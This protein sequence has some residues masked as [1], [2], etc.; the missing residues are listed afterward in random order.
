[1]EKQTLKIVIPMAGLGTRLRPLTYSKP[2]QLVTLAGKA[3]LDHVLDTLSGIP[4]CYE[5]ELINIVGYLGE[6]IEAHITRHYPHLRSHYVVQDDPRGQSHAIYLARH[7]LEGPMLVIFADTLIQTDLSC[8]LDNH[9][10][11]IA[12][13]KPVP[14]PRRFGVAELGEDGYVRRLIEKPQDLSNNLVVVGFYYFKEARQLIEAIAEQMQRGIAING[15]FFLA[16]AI[17]ILLE[18]GLKMTTRTVDV[19]LDAG[20][21][22]ALLE[23][24]RY[25]L[26]NGADN[27]QEA[28]QRPDV[29]IIPPVFI[30]PTAEVKYSVI[31]PHTSLAEGCKV[32][33]SIIRDSILAEAAEVTDAVLE[34]SLVGR[35]AQIKRRP[36]VINAGDQ[37]SL[38]F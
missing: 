35:K 33:S 27:S 16:D 22:E 9:E 4:Q 20:T 11:A 28:M 2:K 34:N 6:Q 30:H 38:S 1:M 13:V 37:T 31:G 25:L 14:D 17:N 12:W 24:N 18:R 5:I 7:L 3:V 29:V 26:E 36:G 10:E 8:L 21:P 19:W 23:S 32:Q 15:E